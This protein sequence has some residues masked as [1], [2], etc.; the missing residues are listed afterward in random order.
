MVTVLFADLSDFTVL[1]GK[2]DAEAVR[3]IV[4]RF[5]AVARDEIRKFAG[6]VEKFVGDAV[7]AVFGLPQAHEDDPLRSVRCALAI[8][9]RLDLL[10]EEYRSA[11]GVTVAIHIGIETGEVIAAAGPSEGR[12]FLLTGDA[13]TVAARLQQVAGPNQILAGERTYRFARERFHFK[14][15]GPLD[16]KGKELPVPAWEV[17]GPLAVPAAHRVVARLVGRERELGELRSLYDQVLASR[18][19]HLV[20]L[21]GPPGV[22]KSRLLYEF[23]AA[24][25]A[26]EPAPALQSGRCLPYAEAVTYLPLAEVLKE[27]CGILDSDPPHVAREKVEAAAGQLG[28]EV[29]DALA[30]TIGLEF[31]GSRIERLDPREVGHELVRAWAAFFEAKARSRPLL[32][33]FDDLHWAADALL[34]LIESMLNTVTDAPLMVVG[35]ARPDLVERRRKW[36][37]PAPAR[38]VLFLDVLSP[39]ESERLLADLL[40]GDLLPTTL[41][42]SILTRAE[43]NPFFLE[44]M[45]RMLLDEGIV[46]RDDRGWRLGTRPWRLDLPDTIQGV[47]GAR[48]DRL[49]AGHKA[50]LHQA[51]V[52]GRTFW[53]GALRALSGDGDYGDALEALERRDFTQERPRPTLAGEREYTFNHVLIQE[54]AYGRLPRGARGRMHERVGEWLEQVA[55]P[56]LPELTELLAHHYQEAARLGRSESSR[57]KAG[58]YLRQAAE[59]AQ[60]RYALDQAIAYAQGALE[61]VPQRERP[62]LH[63]FLGDTMFLAGRVIQAERLY[64]EALK[65]HAHARDRAR[66]HRKLVPTVRIDLA[67]KELER[68]R[69]LLAR[70]PDPAEE[71]TVLIWM[72]RLADRRMEYE[73][74]VRYFQ[75]AR[76]VLRDL[77]RHP[78]LALC[79]YYLVNSLLHVGRFGEAVI[80]AEELAALARDLQ[81]PFISAM[82]HR[83]L[84]EVHLNR[85]EYAAALQA[86]E[87]VLEAGRAVGEEAL[88]AGLRM[89]G[90]VLHRLGRLLEAVEVLQEALRRAAQADYPEVPQATILQALA[91]VMADLGRD[92][93][94]RGM[95][96][97]GRQAAE[98]T[99]HGELVLRMAVAAVHVDTL[100]GRPE[101]SLVHCDATVRRWPN[102]RMLQVQALAAMAESWAEQDVATRAEEAARATLGM[103]SA[104]GAAHEALLARRVLG[105]VGLLKGRPAEAIEYLSEAAEGFLQTGSRLEWARTLT[106]QA[107][108]MGRTRRLDEARALLEQARQVLAECGAA[109]DL[110]RVEKVRAGLAVVRE[111]W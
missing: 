103:A 14:S 8:R 32:V 111:N 19:P 47:I 1:G 60:R 45:V 13:A 81:H 55:G 15:M 106:H 51:A 104:G 38:S 95:L 93:E 56:R 26:R 68:A 101:E 88:A 27:E 108:A 16:L 50:I 25:A 10:N 96:L 80:A 100:A 34:E 66:L 91:M 57:A 17:V 92:T 29:A 44:E 67:V 86:A 94:A 107:A 83:Q 105:R 12:D 82:A 9:E 22:G 2:L 4:A 79:L 21:I 43:G 30:Y 85:A 97:R 49:P 20:M 90:R 65:G 35:T 6:S 40:P 76:G 59:S 31:P 37:Q 24:L 5:F 54:V 36:G 98:A 72:G 87:Q 3:E 109:E 89:K 63:E 102:S 46:L 42:S 110:R 18:Q 23:A 69:E 7:M 28:V 78:D 52:I 84:A 77:G 33:R 11:F 48:I 61:F 71:A 75:T 39:A 53:T 99:G 74:A 41:R 73:E 70:D 58:V 62:A 64:R